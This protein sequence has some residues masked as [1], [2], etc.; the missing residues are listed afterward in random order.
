MASTGLLCLLRNGFQETVQSGGEAMA[1]ARGV[2]PALSGLQL[3]ELPIRSRD[4]EAAEIWLAVMRTYRREPGIIWAAVLLEMLAPLLVVAAS[5]LR[6]LPPAILQEDIEQQLIEEALQA[7]KHMP[8]PAPGRWIPRLV[9]I[10]ARKQVSRWLAAEAKTQ[11]EL[12]EDL[13][14]GASDNG[15]QEEWIETLTQLE[16]MGISAAD[17]ALLY[18]T[19][20]LGETFPSLAFE[21]QTTANALRLRRRRVLARIQRQLAA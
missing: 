2:E 18:R 10:E 20:G 9:V 21:A 6:P 5:R 3:S 8:L 1:A 11:S 17:I 13:D 19:E 4:P 14:A 15:P 12:R 16:L 7:A